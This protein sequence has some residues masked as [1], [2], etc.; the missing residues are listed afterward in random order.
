VKAPAAHHVALASAKISAACLSAWC[1][2]HDILN[3]E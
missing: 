2:S 3:L 1:A